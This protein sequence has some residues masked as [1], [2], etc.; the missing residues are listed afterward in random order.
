MVFVEEVLKNQV[1]IY[2][3]LG[4]WVRGICFEYLHGSA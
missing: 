3:E 2:V 4:N 1:S